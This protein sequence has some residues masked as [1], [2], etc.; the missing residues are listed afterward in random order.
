MYHIID[1]LDITV[2]IPGNFIF[3]IAYFFDI[4]YFVDTSKYFTKL[5]SH[6]YYWEVT[7]FTGIT[8]IVLYVSYRQ[9]HR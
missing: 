4:I 7:L 1:I 9:S 2:N 6:P 3:F 8:I 5:L